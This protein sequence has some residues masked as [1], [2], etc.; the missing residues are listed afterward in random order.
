MNNLDLS[1]LVCTI[2][3]PTIAPEATHKDQVSS[4]DTIIYTL[5]PSPERKKKRKPVAKFVIRTVGLKTH[6]DTETVKEG[7]KK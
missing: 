1:E 7:N 5:P 4:D 3:H 2:M 6:R